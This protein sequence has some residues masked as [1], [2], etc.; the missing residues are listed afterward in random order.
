MPRLPVVVVL[1]SLYN[2]LLCFDKGRLGRSFLWSIAPYR[3]GLDFQD[4][5]RGAE[6]WYW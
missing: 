4:E 1:R 2:G 5:L 3:G 6:V